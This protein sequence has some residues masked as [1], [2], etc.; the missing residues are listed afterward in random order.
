MTDPT[1]RWCIALL[2]AVS[3]CSASRGQQLYF[4]EVCPRIFRNTGE[5]VQYLRLVLNPEP[6]KDA[7]LNN[8]ETLFA[9]IEANKR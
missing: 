1:P 2:A 3:G 8:L 6:R 5:A 7:P 4:G 9:D